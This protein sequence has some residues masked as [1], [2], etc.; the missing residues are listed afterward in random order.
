MDYYAHKFNGSNNSTEYIEFAG[1]DVHNKYLELH[2]M[3][4]NGFK[5]YSI[6]TY[7]IRQFVQKLKGNTAPG[8]DGIS[9][10]HPKICYEK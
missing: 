5:N 2:Y 6:S 8:C 3:S 10:E 9:T 4:M 7:Q 1:Q